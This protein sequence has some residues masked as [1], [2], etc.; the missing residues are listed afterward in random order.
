MVDEAVARAAREVVERYFET[1]NRRDTEAVHGCFNFPHV[2]IGARG[3]VA[4]YENVEANPFGAFLA[5]VDED[6]W[7]HSVLDRLEVI[8]TAP[9]KAHVAIDFRRLR[10]D[11]SQIGAYHSLYVVTSIDGH[12]GIQAGSG[13]GG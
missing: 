11:G 1:L 12:W 10:A 8:F 7:D 2:R 9:Q 5:R 4:Y 3:N 6:G 13:T